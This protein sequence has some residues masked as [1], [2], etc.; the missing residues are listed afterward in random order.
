MQYWLMKTEPSTFSFD[1]LMN[2]PR[3]TTSWDGVRNYQAR[4]FMQEMKVGDQVIIYHSSA[5]PPGAA[6]IAEVA[7][8]AQPDLSAFDPKDHHYDPDS[9]REAPRWFCVDVRG[10]E[11]LERFVSLEE[12]R[13]N[14]ALSGMRL[15]QRGNRLSVLPVSAAE[16]RAIRAMAK[17]TPR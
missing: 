17:R 12:L 7:R 15:L 2:A 13:G 16:F 5:E 11:P 10:V 8:E 4:N 3:R 9:K 1:D 6:G 14:P